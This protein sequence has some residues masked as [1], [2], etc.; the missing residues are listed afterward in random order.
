MQVLLFEDDIR[1]EPFFREHLGALVAHL[2]ELSLDWDL[3]YL[4]RKIL[5]QDE[6]MV[7]FF[8]CSITR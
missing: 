8:S 2:G 6:P 4:G 1:F 3:V 5:K 7:G